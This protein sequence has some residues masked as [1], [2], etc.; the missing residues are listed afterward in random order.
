MQSILKLSIL[1]G[2]TT[3][4]Y[5]AGVPLCEVGVERRWGAA[6]PEVLAR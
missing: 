3:N 2:Q 6:G 1:L 5:T 4:T